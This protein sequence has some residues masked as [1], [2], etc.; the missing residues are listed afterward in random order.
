[1]TGF[2]GLDDPYEPPADP[3]FTL[4]T[5][6]NTVDVNAR[7]ILRA[8]R[9]PRFRGARDQPAVVVALGNTE[10]MTSIIAPARRQPRGPHG[11]PKTG[12]TFL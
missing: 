6:S 5:V 12:T 4:D 1:M 11:A 2:T 7:M 10:T 9:A 3:E 8:L